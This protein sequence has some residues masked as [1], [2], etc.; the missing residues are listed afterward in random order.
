M[1]T[2][3]SKY[4]VD[5]N[6]FMEAA[7]RYYSF[8]FA[9]PFWNGMH[10]YAEQNKILSVDRVLN[11]I[12]KGNDA[13]KEWAQDTFAN[14]FHD[15]KTSE[16]LQSYSELVNWAASQPQYFPNAKNIFM[17]ETNADTWVIAF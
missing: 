4:I 12:K 7:R 8:D 17:E 6:V 1:S 11:E 10:A 15:T 5:S 3:T 14:H 13:L 9:Q 2:S 16:I